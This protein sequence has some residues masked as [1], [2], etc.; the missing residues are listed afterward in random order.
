MLTYKS[1]KYNF[2]LGGLLLLFGLL[3]S[4]CASSRKSASRIT[5]S[6]ESHFSPE[7]QRHYNYFFLEAMRMKQKGNY[8]ATFELLRHCLQLNPQAASALYEISQFYWA[9]KKNDQAE[10]YMKMAAQA[11]PENFWYKQTLAAYYQQATQFDKA[12]D[13]YEQ[14]AVQFPTR[15][16]ILMALTDL[17]NRVNNYPEMIHSLDRLEVIQGKSEELSMNKFR[18]YILMNDQKKAFDEM[19]NLAKEYPYDLRYRTVLG[20]LYLNNGKPETAY[21]TYQ[22]V[23]DKEPDNPMALI[24]LAN[25]YEKT[26]Q[27]ELYQQQIDTILLKKSVASNTKLEIMR[28]CIMRSEQSDRDSTK[29]ID[30]FE[31]TL[32]QPQTDAQLNMLYAQYLISKNMLKESIPVLNN[33]L[34]IDPENTAARMQLLGYAIRDNNPQEVIRICKPA[35]EYTPEILEFH[36]YLSMAYLQ[37]EQKEEAITTLEKAIALINEQTDKKIASDLY[38]FIGDLYHEKKQDAKA[39]AAYDSALAYNPDNVGVLNNYAYFLTLENK[40]LDKAEEMSFR[41]IKAEPKNATFLDTYAWILFIKGRYTEA[42]LYI[43]SALQNG[44]T[45]SPDEVE[46]AGDIYYHC[47]EKEKALEFWEKAKELG[48]ESKT[49]DRKIQLK[50]YIKP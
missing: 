40:D 8:D 35:T 23:L 14:M 1:I 41:T 30:L 9:L 24:S 29:I 18:V 36:F 20:D 12:I 6:T 27:D 4:S 38:S 7:E 5:A 21:S 11:D 39:Y 34:T 46:H 2:L 47:G 44:G 50:K 10:Q 15:Q 49:I 19:E 33:I 26:G 17:Y 37:T 13:V 45:E 28:Q 31:R 43:D 16:E 32:Q 25:Y 48:V 42:K 22:Q 3:N